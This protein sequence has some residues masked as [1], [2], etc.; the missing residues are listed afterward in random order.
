MIYKWC[1]KDFIRGLLDYWISPLRGDF[2]TLLNCRCDVNMKIFSVYDSKTGAYLQ[3]FF[4]KTKGAAIR[5]F[6]EIVSDKEHQFGKYPADFILF[7]L[8]SWSE[9]DGK[10]VPLSS[11]ISL[12]VGVDFLRENPISA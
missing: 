2:L 12:G 4:M 1:S 10:F 3:P 9:D 8:G 11:P 5:A 6:T 7:E